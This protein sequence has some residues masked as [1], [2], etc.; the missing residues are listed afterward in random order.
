MNGLVSSPTIIMTMIDMKNN[1]GFDIYGRMNDKIHASTNSML[2][3][4]LSLMTLR[5]YDTTTP[6]HDAQQYV[7]NTQLVRRNYRRRIR[8][9]WRQCRWNV[10]GKG[11]CSCPATEW[12]EMYYDCR[13]ACRRLRHQTDLQSLQEEF[14]LQRCRP[15]G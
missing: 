10:G 4:S 13:G 5:Q 3:I 6:C 2:F 7:T 14:Q 8:G 9:C 1:H 11:P 15:E 12:S